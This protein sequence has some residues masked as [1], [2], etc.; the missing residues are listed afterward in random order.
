MKPF[1]II[2]ISLSPILSV[3]QTTISYTASTA[4]FPNPE[5]GFYR[6]TATHSDNYTPLDAATLAGYRDLHTPY[7]AGYDIYSTLVLRM[8]YLD[9]F[10]SSDISASYLA[11]MQADF[12]AARTAGVKLIV[13]FAYTNAVDGSSCANWICPPYGDA[14]KTWTLS[15]LN[16]LQ[17]YLVANKDVIALCQLG[18]IGTWGEGYYTDHFGDASQSPYILTATNWDDRTELV[19]AYLAALPSDRM[20]QVRYPQAKQKAVFGNMAPTTSAAVAPSEA[21]NGTAIARIGH[22]NDC[23]LASYT[24]FGTYNNYGP[25]SSFADTT[26]LKPYVENDSK[27]V[28]VGGETCAEYIPFDNCASDGGRADTELRRLHYS[29]LNSQYNNAVN[30]GW[31]NSCLENIKKNLGYR[32]VLTDGTYTNEAQPGQIIAVDINLENVGYAAPFNPR[33]AEIILRHTNTGDLFSATLDTEPRLW[34]SGVHNITENL[35]LPSNIPLGDYELLLNLAD[36]ETSLY[37]R[38]EYSIRLANIGT[39]EANTGYN[40][41]GHILTI[42]NTAAGTACSSETIFE[43][44]SI[45]LPVELTEFYVTAK[46]DHILCE[47]ETAS[48]INNKGFFLQRSTDSKNWEDIKWIDGINNS[49]TSNYYSYQDE[50]VKENTIYYYRLKQVDTDYSI[51]Y[52]IIQS[53]NIYSNEKINREILIQPNPSKNNITIQIPESAN[54]NSLLEI[55]NSNGDLIFT[56]KINNEF[57]LKLDISH[58]N[59]GLFHVRII[60]DN[61]IWFGQFVHY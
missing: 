8:F 3:A 30:N 24:D 27:Y 48:E 38:P 51:N 10:T 58:F 42:N 33:D 52:S 18:F 35:C 31:M 36:P 19:N 28:V 60:K 61:D 20:L 37:D 5:R 49:Y 55:Y 17:P 59:L 47:W 40:N 1:I 4:D 26:N 45:T 43:S 13:R 57:E 56:K 39:W 44:Q 6:Y 53:A 46:K 14:S 23:L 15:H 12:D 16:Q 32:L 25:P 41:L 50:N 2:L 11:N 34:L 9:D 54:N 7:S 22:H 21:Y 29:Y